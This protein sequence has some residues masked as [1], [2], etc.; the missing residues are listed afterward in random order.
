MA[1][2]AVI[3]NFA[4]QIVE[5][6]KDDASVH[7]FYLT[8][9][10]HSTGQIALAQPKPAEKNSILP[11]RLCLADAG[12]HTQPIRNGDAT[13]APVSKKRPRPEPDASPRTK[14]PHTVAVPP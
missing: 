12:S 5:V 3:R 2:Q 7:K 8:R 9:L 6:L 4:A 10:G 1:E 13:I 11:S 14:R